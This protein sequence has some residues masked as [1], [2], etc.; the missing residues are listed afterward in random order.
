VNKL[1]ILTSSE[2]KLIDKLTIEKGIAS[3]TLM[4]QAAFSVADI[5][6]TFE[7]TSILC[8]V[9]KGNN[10][11]DGIAA[12][13]ILKN[14]G[15]DV[16]ILIVGDPT[17]GSP[18]FKKQLEI[19]KKYEINIYRSRIDEINYSQYDLII[20][21]LIGIGL[22][23]E[24]K[25]DVAQAITRINSSGSKVLSVDVPSGISSDTGEVM[26]TAV[27]ADQTVT[28]GFLKIGQLLY[29][30]REY[31]G[32]IKVAPLSF[33]NS[34]INSINR[35][36]ILENTVKNLLPNRP[37]D[38]YKYKFGTVLILAGSEKY[39]GAPILSAIGAQKT[40]AGMVKLITPGDSSHVLALEPSIIYRSLKK[41]HFE[42][43]DVDNLKEEIE[44]SNVI[45]LGPGI[46]EKAKGFVTK[47]VNTY[48]DNKMF[49]LDADALSILKEK[50]VKLNKNFVITPHVGELSKV[51]KNVKNDVFSLEEY[52]KELNCTIVFKS[53][54]TLITNGEKTYFN[55]TGNSSLA[56]GGSGDLLSGVIGSYIAQ[57]LTTMQACL[58]GSYVV[59]KTARDLSLD[60]TNYCLTPK[61]IADNLYKTI[62]Q[63]NS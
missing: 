19:A 49:V 34:L 39:P 25:G 23:G 2:A 9:G 50:D 60:Y 22:T 29:P 33:D 56:K 20:D 16:E 14:R 13:R 48:K 8:V 37:E 41:E 46:S 11:G 24:V 12:G 18:G 51:Y 44:K 43:K 28:F 58:I 63:L 4:E 38:S 55:I 52:A 5:A 59:Y 31:C 53:S 17:Q 10:A 27:K 6:Q 57:G 42:E 61:I 26:G 35:E 62:Q 32:E 7:P 3:E 15:Y 40:G 47:L 1:K 45:V 30:A 36:L 54:T 21:G